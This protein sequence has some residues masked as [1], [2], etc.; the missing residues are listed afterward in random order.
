[1]E[2]YIGLTFTLTVQHKTGEDNVKFVVIPL[3]ILYGTS[4][5]WEQ[6]GKEKGS[7]VVGKSLSLI[8][9]KA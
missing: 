8:H 6:E 1:M 2:A 3:R 9:G 7:S 4:C 5:E